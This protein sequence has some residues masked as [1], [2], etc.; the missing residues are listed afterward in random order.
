MKLL[1]RQRELATP[2]PPCCQEHA[3]CIVLRISTSSICKSAILRQ[4][5]VRI[6]SPALQNPRHPQDSFF[7]SV[8][9][10]PKHTTMLSFV[11]QA[12]LYLST[13]ILIFSVS[14]FENHKTCIVAGWGRREPVDSRTRSATEEHFLKGEVSLSARGLFRTA[15]LADRPQIATPLT[16]KF[17]ALHSGSASPEERRKNIDER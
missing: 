17:R 16:P 3:H 9:C 8:R 12:F 5:S 4:H 1:I 13:L 6:R 15:P 7:N 14:T 11:R 10:P 2:D